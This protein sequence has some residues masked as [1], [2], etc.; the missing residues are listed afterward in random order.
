M[1]ICEQ[2]EGPHGLSFKQTI[3]ALMVTHLLPVLQQ[4]SLKEVLV[5][6]MPIITWIH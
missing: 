2:A 6:C 5:R 3:T 4:M 1:F